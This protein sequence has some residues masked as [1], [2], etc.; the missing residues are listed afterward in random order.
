MCC[1]F[2]FQN[3]DDVYCWVDTNGNLHTFDSAVSGY[4]KGFSLRQYPLKWVAIFV[5][6]C[7]M[8]IRH[9]S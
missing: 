5:V 7:A 3:D 4:D 1:V 6:Y 8:Y 2:V 9:L